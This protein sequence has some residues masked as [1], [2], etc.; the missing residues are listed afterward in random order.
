MPGKKMKERKQKNKKLVEYES[1]GG[2]M[3]FHESTFRTSLGIL[4][5]SHLVVAFVSFAYTCC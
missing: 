5:R 1:T 4:E 2:G 3:N